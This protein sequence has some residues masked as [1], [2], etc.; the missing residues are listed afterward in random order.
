MLRWRRSGM[1]PPSV[2][3]AVVPTRTAPVLSAVP[4][5]GITRSGAGER[6]ELLEAV[7]GDDEDGGPTDLDFDG[8]GHEEITGLNQ[9]RHGVHELAAGPAVFLDQAE[10]FLDAI[11]LDAGHQRNVLVLQKAARA[12]KARH[13]D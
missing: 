1:T 4:S 3:P 13:R 5:P 7:D 10:H 6:S 12:G 11:V 2:R 9:G 8:I